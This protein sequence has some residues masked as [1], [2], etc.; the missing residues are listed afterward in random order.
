MTEINRLHKKQTIALEMYETA[1]TLK[2]KT[3][4]SERKVT[5]KK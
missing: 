1:S 4:V 2:N 3:V 5:E